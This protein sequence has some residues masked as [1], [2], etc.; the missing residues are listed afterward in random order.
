MVR[1][2]AVL[3]ASRSSGDVMR[4]TTPFLHERHAVNGPQGRAGRQEMR[5]EVW[6]REVR[7]IDF[8]KRAGGFFPLM[9]AGVMSNLASFRSEYQK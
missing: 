9:L 3:D 6:T 1:S 7:R 2:V 5:V 4:Q 8:D